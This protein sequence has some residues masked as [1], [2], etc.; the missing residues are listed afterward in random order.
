MLLLP[1]ALRSLNGFISAPS[2]TAG[3]SVGRLSVSEGFPLRSRADPAIS[4]FALHLIA[5]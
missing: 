1:A 5:C 3:S 4:S 2:E